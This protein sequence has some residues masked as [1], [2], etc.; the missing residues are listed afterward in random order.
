MPTIPPIGPPGNLTLPD[1]KAAAGLIGANLSKLPDTDDPIITS[2][3]HNQ[4][5]H[6]SLQV[7][8]YPL[9][10]HLELIAYLLVQALLLFQ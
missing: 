8:H 3:F 1:T 7:Y 9:G 2:A 6:L 10:L 5:S 4:I